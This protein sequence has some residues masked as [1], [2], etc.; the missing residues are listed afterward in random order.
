VYGQANL[1]AKTT[2]ARTLALT[3]TVDGVPFDLGAVNSITVAAGSDTGAWAAV[4]P[5]VTAIRIVRVTASDGNGLHD[6]VVQI[7]LKPPKK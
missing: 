5:A 6:R 7:T 3:A 4:V 2:T 1:T